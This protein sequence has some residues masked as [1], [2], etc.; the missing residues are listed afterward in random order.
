V[1]PHRRRRRRRG[2]FRLFRRRAFDGRELVF[3]RRSLRLED[4]VD[5]VVLDLLRRVAPVEVIVRV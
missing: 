4:D 2:F 1:L 3:L 5:L